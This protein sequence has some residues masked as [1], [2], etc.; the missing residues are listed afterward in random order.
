[1]TPATGY[2]D[3]DSS[4][5]P[6]AVADS[7]SVAAV[8]VTRNRVPL[9]RQ[10]LAALKASTYPISEIIVS[11]DSSD[12]ETSRMLAAEFPEAMRIVGPQR[13]IAANRNKGMSFAKSDYILLSDDDMLVDP[14]FVE[15]AMQEVANSEPGLIF[16]GTTEHGEV[17]FPNTL[18]FLG[19]SKQPYRPGMTYNTANQQCF[20]LSSRLARELPYD[21][22]IEAYGYEEMDFAYR[23]AASG[24]TIDCVRA[25]SNIHLAPNATSVTRPEKDA[26]RIYVTYKRAAYVDRRPLKA[27]AFLAVAVPHHLLSCVRRYGPKGIAQALSNFRLAY[28][29]HREYRRRVHLGAAVAT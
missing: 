9:L 4:G 24:V 1:M 14:R 5:Q 26:C 12:E 8:I 28:R 29:M 22:V 6:R 19:F 15:L 2:N 21:E 11:D 10:T 3:L 7:P 27:L 20:L 17:I 25:C 18:N 23:V 13:G 16:T